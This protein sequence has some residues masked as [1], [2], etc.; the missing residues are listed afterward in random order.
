L[1]A[2]VI[3]PVAVALP[4][5]GVRSLRRLLVIS[6]A[7]AVAAVAAGYLPDELGTHT[8]ILEAFRVFAIAMVLG[9]VFFFLYQSSARLRASGREFRQ[10][11]SLS[12]ELAETTDPGVLGELVARH[13]AEAIGFDDCVIYALAPET[14]R[15]APFGSYPPQRALE[16]EP[17]SLAERPVLGRVI[18][19]RT[20]IVIDVADDGADPAERARVRALGRRVMLL[21][22]LFARQEPVGAAELTSS[23]SRAIDDR[24]LSL[25]ATLAFEAAMAIENGRLYQQLRHKALHD[26]LTG[27]ANRGLFFD[28]AEQA[29]ARLHRREGAI[30][31][32]A[33]I[34]LDDFKGV[35]DTLG[36][37]RGDH[38]LT[39]VGER[40]GAVVRPSDTVARFG[41]DEFA[42]LLEEL[43]SDDEALATAQRVVRSLERPFELAGEPVTISASIGVSTGS[44]AGVDVVELVRQADAAMY[45]AK[46]TGRGRAVLF[47]AGAPV[48]FA[49]RSGV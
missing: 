34:D 27:L 9:L 41:G 42:L 26:P 6:W 30:L 8:A 7:G 16:E 18:R 46:R 29:V 47:E 28:R 1:A 44:A 21:M 38:L 45:E 33:F 10:L 3:I 40:L 14:D 37:A 20:R 35:N 43:E 13:L 23:G 22:P 15:L 19:D 11:L 24:Q 31:A 5:V 36:H 32:V 12:A 2:A 39:L 48:E 25:A 4:Y 17:K 49:G